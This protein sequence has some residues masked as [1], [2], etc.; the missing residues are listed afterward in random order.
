[1]TIP[2][3]GKSSYKTAKSYRPIS[4]LSC[5]GETIEK[6]AATRILNA[7]KIC[8]AISRFQFGN[9]D[10]HS[11]SDVL[12]QTLTHL[13][14]HLLSQIQMNCSYYNLKRPLLTAHDILG[15][16]NNTNPDILVQIIVQQGMPT[17]LINWTRNFTA[18]RTLSFSFDNHLKLP[19]PFKN[20]ILQGSPGSP[21]LF[22]IMMS[23]VM[24]A[25]DKANLQTCTAYVDDLNEIYAD[26]NIGQVIPVLS[27]ALNLKARCAAEIGLSFA[28]DKSEVIRFSLSARRKSKC[29]KYYTLAYTNM[30]CLNMDHCL[31]INDC[32][33]SYVLFY[34]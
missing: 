31:I 9:K 26:K 19:K 5:L 17:Y 18:D 8:G 2:K 22:S 10:S 24:D 27:N 6:I 16:F 14:P 3:Q 20:V 30:G 33:L 4:L 28:S 1:V 7:G 13:L 12:L 21:I 15:A 11:A 23:A 25:G 34:V 32:C 29:K